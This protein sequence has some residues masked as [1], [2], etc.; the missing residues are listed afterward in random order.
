[1][2]CAHASNSLRSSDTW[3][4]H[5]ATASSEV[6]ELRASRFLLTRAALSPGGR[7][8]S[9]SVPSGSLG[10]RLGYEDS[11]FSGHSAWAATQAPGYPP[12]HELPAGAHGLVRKKQNGLVP[13]EGKN[14]PTRLFARHAP[15]NEVVVRG[16]NTSTECLECEFD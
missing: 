9:T 11:G 7:A 5:R 3:T 2:A 4:T 16:E 13:S 10:L 6:A 8:K 14:P 1:M 12:R 15:W